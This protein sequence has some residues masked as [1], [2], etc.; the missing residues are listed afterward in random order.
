[1]NTIT[2][3]WVV[4]SIAC[5]AVGTISTGIIWVFS[6]Q[7]EEKQP[8]TYNPQQIA[9]PT[10]SSSTPPVR[11]A[12]NEAK[13][14]RNEEWGFEFQYPRDW[15]VGEDSFV[16]YNVKFNVQLFPIAGQYK[17]SFPILIN[18]VSSDFAKHTFLGFN[19]TTSTVA[20]DG[21]LGIKYEYEFEGLPE[22]AIVLPFGQYS[23]IIGTGSKEDYEDVFNQIANSFKLLK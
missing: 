13:T 10:A 1:M 6:K 2:K 9:T 16:T 23:I 21:V 19:A 12:D 18:I 11:V 20:V 14:Y 3:K 8:P 7:Q 22:V 5:I 4:I 17:A 15:K